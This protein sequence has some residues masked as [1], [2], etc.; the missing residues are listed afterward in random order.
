M[1]RMSGRSA[2]HSNELLMM[3]ESG[4]QKALGCNEPS[5]A[6]NVIFHYG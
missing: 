6:L 4:C 5:L 3:L 1:L 2:S